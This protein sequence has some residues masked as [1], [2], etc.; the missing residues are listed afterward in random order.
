MKYYR[1]KFHVVPTHYGIEHGV[2]EMAQRGIGR[3]SADGDIETLGPQSGGKATRPL[4]FEVAA[5]RDTADY[6]IAPL[7]RV[8]GKFRSSDHI[9][10]HI[11]AAH[12]RVAAVAA[13]VRQ[14][15]I[16]TGEIADGGDG[17]ELATQRRRR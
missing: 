8:D 9:P 13:V 4:F 2:I 5:I 10:H 17:L 14:A 3:N 15:Q 16:V 1:G 12:V 6:G 11:G 7:L